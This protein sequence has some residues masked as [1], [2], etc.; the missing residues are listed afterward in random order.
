MNQMLHVLVIDDNR[1]DR[2]LVIRELKR[3]FA[4]LQVQEIIDAS[5]L[6]T[7]LAAGA[8]NVVITDYQ[9]GWTN[10]LNILKAIKEL[11]P[12][13]PVIM[14]TDTGSEEIAVE[15]MK[16]GLDD[17]ILKSATRYVLIPSVVKIALERA[18]NRRQAALLEIRLRGLLNHL[19]VG[20]F[21]ANFDG[22]YIE[23]NPAFLKILGVENL[24]QLYSENILDISGYYS[25]LEQS[26]PQQQLE[27]QVQCADG[28]SIWVALDITL[29]QV[30]GEKLLDGLIE[31]ISARKL[32][33][34]ER[35]QANQILEQRVQERTAELEAANQK[36]VVANQDLETFTYSVSHDLREPLRAIQGFSTILQKPEL[37][38]ERQQ[39][40]LQR[41][42]KSVQS[43]TT[44][45][46]DL[47]AY[48]RIS[49]GE[50]PLKPINLSSCVTEVLMNLEPELNQRQVTVQ[51]EQPLGSVIGNRTLINQIITNLVTNAIKF[52]APEVHP[53]L[54]IRTEDTNNKTRL[55]I[56]DNGIGIS[57]QYLERIFNVFTRL[58]SKE[59][60]PG[61]G[62]GLAIVRKG[63]ERMNASIGVESQ[64]GQGSKFWIE[65]NSQLPT[66][67][68]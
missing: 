2:G 61:T 27:I 50:L 49:L 65:F 22:T 46:D 29:N 7:A 28:T 45:I 24:Q 55:W 9:L 4:Q 21:R 23:A 31:D 52:V 30:D 39:E 54:R 33:E 25:T 56:E 48:S 14:F 1:A 18:Q 40:Y 8:F 58:H 32:A 5:G 62:I 68:S 47:L 10:G 41:I 15:A 3:E 13:C 43:A 37:E 51:V 38:K 67:N 60:Y 12:D 53:I 20:V 34:V 64:P 42:I 16:S 57:E 19:Q 36:L 17:Y 11:Y 66:P 59:Q 63:A 26:E 6:A 35:E 44:L